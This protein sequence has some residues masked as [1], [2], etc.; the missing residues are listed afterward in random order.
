MSNMIPY[1]NN[2]G[3]CYHFVNHYSSYMIIS[4]SSNRIQYYTLRPYFFSIAQILKIPSQRYS[5]SLGNSGN[6]G[7]NQDIQPD[8]ALNALKLILHCL[9]LPLLL[10]LLL[11]SYTSWPDPPTLEFNTEQCY[12]YDKLLYHWGKNAYLCQPVIAV[13]FHLENFLWCVSLS[14]S[15][16]WWLHTW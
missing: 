1:Y 12:R 13:P 8:S 7:S 2:M 11:Y 4:I 10:L 14:L 3:L 9:L 6:L 5:N 15:Q 16:P